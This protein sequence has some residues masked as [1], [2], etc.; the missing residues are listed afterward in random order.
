M[1]QTR[2]SKIGKKINRADMDAD[3]DAENKILK[4]NGADADAQNWKKIQQGGRGCRKLK[5]KTERT[6]TPKIEKKK[7]TGRTRTLEINRADGDVDYYIFK[8]TG[9]TRTRTPKFFKK[10]NQQG[11][12]GTASASALFFFKKPNVSFLKNKTYL[13]RR[14]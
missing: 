2:T 11:G 12:C 10:T 1:G 7:S 5:K 9:R 4:I 14:G 3:A 8:S 6:G 13:N